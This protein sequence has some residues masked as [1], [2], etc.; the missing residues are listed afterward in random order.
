MI[1]FPSVGKSTLMNAVA[2]D[3][4]ERE[5]KKLSAVGGVFLPASA[6][7]PQLRSSH[8]SLVRATASFRGLRIHHSYV[9][10]VCVHGRG[11]KN[12]TSGFARDH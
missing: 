8:S 12:P 3:P 4:E 9:S 10:A 6:L 2:V 7:L 5:E 1:G 11:R